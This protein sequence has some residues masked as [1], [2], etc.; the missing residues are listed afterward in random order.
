MITLDTSAILA[1][2]DA[3]DPRHASVASAIGSERPPFLVPSAILAE[4][5]YLIERDLGPE[6]MDAFLDDL[7]HGRL[8]FDCAPAD[9]ERIRVLVGRYADLSLGIADAAVIACAERSGRR[10]LT[11][12]RRDFEV[13]G[14]EVPLTLLP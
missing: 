6:A 3:G 14:R 4:V 1:L 5:G 11:L 10:V 12:D 8:T 13:V 7:V 2:L 9:L